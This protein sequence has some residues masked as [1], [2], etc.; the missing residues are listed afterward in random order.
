MSPITM[1]PTT[2]KRFAIL[3]VALLAT[4]SLSALDVGGYLDNTT[5]LAKAPVAHA[6]RASTI[7]RYDSGIAA[8]VSSF[9]CER[10]FMQPR[11]LKISATAPIAQK[12]Q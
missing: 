10:K 9:I 2:M 4:V 1:N 5:G 3:L 6:G 8:T 12:L 11:P 7:V